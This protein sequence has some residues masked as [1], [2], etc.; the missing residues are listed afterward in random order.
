MAAIPAR[1]G[2]HR[3]V[4]L[5]SLLIVGGL[6]LLVWLGLM[7]S[8]AWFV[9]TQLDARMVLREQPVTLRLPAGLQAQA[10]VQQPVHTGIDMRPLVNVPVRQRL[11]AQIDDTLLTRVSFDATVP[12]DT[13]VQVDQVVTVRTELSMQVPLVGWLPA[14]DV[15]LP[16]VLSLPFK[17]DVPVRTQVPVRLDA[18][19]SGELRAP[20]E[21]PLDTVFRLR[22]QIRGAVVARIQGQMDFVVR[23]AMPPMALTIEHA[24]LLAPFELPS[25]RPSVRP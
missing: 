6:V 21:V 9:Y 13:V 4:S 15:T 18:L 24:R 12:V 8:A 22:P 14:F 11:R 5:K 19:V 3:P 25:I 7:L 20:I 1:G 16:V 10:Q 23:D 2:W 17:A